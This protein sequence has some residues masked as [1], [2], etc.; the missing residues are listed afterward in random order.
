VG[1]T[2]PAV[3]AALGSRVLFPP[4]ARRDHNDQG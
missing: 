3:V 1:F 2:V 4:A